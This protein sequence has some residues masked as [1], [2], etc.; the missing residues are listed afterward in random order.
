ME[1][2]LVRM[3]RFLSYVLRHHPE[4]EGLT[5]DE[6]GW[7][8]VEELLST[9]GARK[10]GMT[11][12][13]LERVV[14]ENDK[15]RFEL[16]QA[17]ERIR[18]RQGH[19]RAVD[20]GWKTVTPPQYLYHGTSSRAIPSI[21]EAGLE[22]RNRH[23]VHLSRDSATANKVGARHGRPVVLTVRAGEMGDAGYEFFLSG[24][25]VWLVDCVPP[26]FIEFP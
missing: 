17:G 24:N 3:S 14:A 10:R 13:L 21:R 6:H 25:G 18:A 22:R 5:M 2:R 26:Q 16:D 4:A 20:L 12:L 11:Q 7:V 8:T 15:Q 9:R 19:S 1:Q 23:H